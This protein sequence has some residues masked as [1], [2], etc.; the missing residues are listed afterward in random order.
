MKQSLYTRI[1]RDGTVRTN[2]FEY[3]K[4]GNKIEKRALNPLSSP[5]FEWTVVKVIR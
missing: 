5:H 3:R 4:I 1:I 2:R